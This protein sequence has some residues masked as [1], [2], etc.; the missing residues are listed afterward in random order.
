MFF[1]LFIKM[2]KK[3]KWKKIQMDYLN[4][5]TELRSM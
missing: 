3:D 2:E 1:Y 4:I 5:A